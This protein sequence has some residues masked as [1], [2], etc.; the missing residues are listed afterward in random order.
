MTTLQH[1]VTHSHPLPPTF[2]HFRPPLPGSP[3][4]HPTHVGITFF[5][6]S[7]I[8]SHLLHFHTSPPS[9]FR[10][11]QFICGCRITPTTTLYPPPA[12]SHQPPAT[13]HHP[14]SIPIRACLWV[15]HSVGCPLAMGR[16]R[17]W[18][19]PWV[20]PLFGTPRG[21]A[22]KSFKIHLKTTWQRMHKHFSALYFL[23][24]RTY[25]QT[26]RH[27]NALTYVPRTFAGD[28]DGCTLVDN[29]VCSA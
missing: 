26:D 16:R 3:G 29:P 25:R 23:Y 6:I 11:Q 13:T 4:P 18:T 27:S 9:S 24:A 19:N 14:P 7:G 22:A 21:C 12:N 1:A 2:A 5:A 10:C 15:C 17:P 20:C 28:P 8:V